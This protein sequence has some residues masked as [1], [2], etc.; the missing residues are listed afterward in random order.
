ME[1]STYPDKKYIESSRMWVN[2]AC[3]TEKT[4]MVDA[5]VGGKK[6]TVCSA[7]WNIPCEAHSKC[8]SAS[9]NY[10][11]IT[12]LPTTVYADPDGKEL[13]REVGGMGASQLIKKQKEL[14]EKIPGEKISADEWMLVKNLGQDAESSFS[15]GEW[16]KAIEVYTRISKMPKKVFKDKGT[17]GLGKVNEKG[18]ELIADA[19]AKV[20]T[21]KEEAK[22]ILKTVASDFK[23]LECSKEAAAALKEIPADETK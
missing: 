2:V 6:V 21:E 9:G 15:K 4:H 14:L 10:P 1:S 7:Y 19:K 11:G 5:M 23:P 17:K 12:G 3:H 13:A 18:R 16:K 22:K 20:E 8:Y